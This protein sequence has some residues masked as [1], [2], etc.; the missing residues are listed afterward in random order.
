[1]KSKLNTR[2]NI[3]KEVVIQN[4]L[5]LHAR[6]AATIVKMVQDAD[7]AIWLVEGE[8][9]VDA[10]SVIEILTLNAKKGTQL[11]IEIES[12][13]DQGILDQLVDFFQSGFG[14]NGDS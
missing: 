8:H 4:G 2:L 7:K 13:N 6:P 3:Q 14:E 11:L 10:S 1:M 12:E 5:G 9:R